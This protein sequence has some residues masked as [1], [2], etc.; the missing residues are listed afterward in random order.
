[1][2]VTLDSRTEIPLHPL[3]LTFYG[4]SLSRRSP[5]SQAETR[6]VSSGVS[7]SCLGLIQS[8]PSTSTLTG[9]ADIVLGVPFMRSV[10]TVM[11]YDP[12]D[13]DGVFPN[14]SSGLSQ[15]RVRVC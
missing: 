15:V 13:S 12:P 10:Y 4:S 6:D 8:F 11:A 9:I 14:I 7:N 5:R 3:D 2:S 1:M